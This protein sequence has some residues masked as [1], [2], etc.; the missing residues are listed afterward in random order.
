MA[1]YFCASFECSF[2]FVIL[3][4]LLPQ[5]E[6]LCQLRRPPHQPVPA[7]RRQVRRRR[8]LRRRGPLRRRRR[9]LRR[10]RR[11]RRR[12]PLLKKKN[13]LLF[14]C[15]NYKSHHYTFCAVVAVGRFNYTLIDGRGR[16]NLSI[17]YTTL[18]LPACRAREKENTVVNVA[19]QLQHTNPT[20]LHI[21]ISP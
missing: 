14:F 8:L 18:H 5:F 21:Y 3:P 12:P 17:I 7:V 9:I 15:W 4:I 6:Q 16:A 19:L 11:I 1:R 2:L 13:T 10:R 20:K